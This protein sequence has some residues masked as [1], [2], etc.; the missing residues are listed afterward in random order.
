MNTVN[1]FLESVSK[2]HIIKSTYKRMNNLSDLELKELKIREKITDKENKLDFRKNFLINNIN[3]EKEYGITN[4]PNKKSKVEELVDGDKEDIKKLRNKL[5]LL[6]LTIS[7][8]RR[9]LRLTETI[10][11]KMGDVNE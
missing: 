9:L 11:S 1:N 6:V 10:L 7:R 2:E 5:N 4:I 8:E 3:F